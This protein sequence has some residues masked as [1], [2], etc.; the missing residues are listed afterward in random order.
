VTPATGLRAIP[1]KAC[2]RT[3]LF[4]QTGFGWSCC[5]G[6]GYAMFLLYNRSYPDLN[7]ERIV[8]GAHINAVVNTPDC[9]CVS[10]AGSIARR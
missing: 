1:E 8:C 6:G 7:S 3:I 5:P 2:C 10:A 9:E 4:L